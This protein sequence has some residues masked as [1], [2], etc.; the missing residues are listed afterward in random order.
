MRSCDALA[1]LSNVTGRA[2]WTYDLTLK[3]AYGWLC[4]RDV[5]ASFPF[6]AYVLVGLISYRMRLAACSPG[7]AKL[8]SRRYEMDL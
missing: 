5:V 1:L 4:V 8:C 3:L 6:H 7:R 2:A